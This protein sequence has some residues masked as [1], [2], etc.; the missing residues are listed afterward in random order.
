M[1]R[2]FLSIALVLSLALPMPV[3]AQEL[4]TNP[5]VTMS[6]NVSDNQDISGEVSN[7]DITVRNL[8]DI[9]SAPTTGREVSVE[10]EFIKMMSEDK[11]ASLSISTTG[12]VT[13]NLNDYIQDGSGSFDYRLKRD[14]AGIEVSETGVITGS[15]TRS[16]DFVVVVT[17]T[18][19]PTYKVEL[20]FSI[21]V[22]EIEV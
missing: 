8:V 5:I 9:Q 2:R 10:S 17:D 20:E 18:V 4:Q 16:K 15:L 1:F 6:E 14:I 19:Y 3:S 22:E 13:I 11:S 12:A 21:T 7:N